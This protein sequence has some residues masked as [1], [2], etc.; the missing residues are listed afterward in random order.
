MEKYYFDTDKKSVKEEKDEKI[1]LDLLKSKLSGMDISAN[2]IGRDS[3]YRATVVVQKNIGTSM[4]LASGSD[5]LF[6]LNKNAVKVE[7][8]G[9]IVKYHFVFD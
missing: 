2:I 7:N 3:L 1:T 5:D 6:W 4:F 8:K 9:D